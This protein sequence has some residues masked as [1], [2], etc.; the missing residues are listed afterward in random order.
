MRTDSQMVSN[1]ARGGIEMT[2]VYLP[3]PDGISHMLLMFVCT[4]LKLQK[5]VIHTDGMRV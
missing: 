2:V 3:L 4:D 5:L 1:S